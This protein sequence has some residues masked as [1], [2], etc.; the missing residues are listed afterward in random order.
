MTT[1][2]KPMAQRKPMESGKTFTPRTDLPHLLEIMEIDT[3]SKN[4]YLASLPFGVKDTTAGTENEL[5]AVVLE[6]G[7]ASCRERV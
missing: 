7:R 6:I 3:S 2:L 5:Q 1:Q 4:K